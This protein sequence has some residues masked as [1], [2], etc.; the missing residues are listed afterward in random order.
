[1]C[2]PIIGIACIV[3]GGCASTQQDSRVFVMPSSSTV[4]LTTL[5][6]VHGPSTGQQIRS[7]RLGAGDALGEQIYANYAVLARANAGWQYASG[8]TTE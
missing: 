6:P 7:F 8:S 5:E 4:A 3:V 1:M 2:F